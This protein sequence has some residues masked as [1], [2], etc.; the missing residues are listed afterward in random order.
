MRMNKGMMLALLGVSF[1]VQGCALLLVGAGAGAGVGTYAY[2]K[3]ELQTTYGASVDRTWNATL[4]ALRDLNIR[5]VSTRKDITE[6]DIEA[7]KADGT[8]VRIDLLKAGPDTTT[9]KIRVGTFGD[10]E[11]SK[12]IHRRIADILGIKA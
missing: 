12:L 9:V 8:R 3:G 6:G 5:V 1:M 11:F 2:V 7:A 10:E 4:S